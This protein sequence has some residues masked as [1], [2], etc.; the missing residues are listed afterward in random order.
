MQADA[1]MSGFI[2]NYFAVTNQVKQGCVLPPTLFS[3]FLSAMLE[4]R[5]EA[6]LFNVTYFKS[7]TKTTIGLVRDLLFADD[8]QTLDNIFVNAARNFRL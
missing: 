6:D 2:S 8:M 1:A 5:K 7:K 4:L 3:I